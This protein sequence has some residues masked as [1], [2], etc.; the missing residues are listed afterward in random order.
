MFEG[1]DIVGWESLEG[2]LKRSDLTDEDEHVLAEILEESRHTARVGG[3][4]AHVENIQKGLFKFAL[5]DVL[6][7]G[8]D[9]ADFAKRIGKILEG[10]ISL[11]NEVVIKAVGHVSSETGLVE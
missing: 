6:V 10:S 4:N 2:L 11:L 1:L 9:I 7:Q 3:V 8:H 5:G